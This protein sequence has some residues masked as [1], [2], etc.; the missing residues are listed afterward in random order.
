MPRAG[1]IV[2]PAAF[3]VL[4]GVAPAGAKNFTWSFNADILTLDPHSS[5]NTFTNA[6]ANNL[7]EG[8]TR[9]NEKIEIEPA[10]AERWELVNPT[11]WRFHLRRDVRFHDGAAFD[12][13]DVLFTWAR[14]N[15]PGA[16]ARRVIGDVKE[17]RRVDS[18]TVEIE[19]AQPNP[20]LLTA[21]THFFVMDREWSERN[22]SAAATNL[23][24][25][26]E[27]GAARQAN[28]TGPFRLV[29]R[30]P[31]ER[32]VLAVN[33]TWWDRP[34]HNLTEV[35]FQPIR[36]AATR[37]AALISGAIDATVEIPIQDIPRIE[38]SPALK[39][40]QGPELRTIYFGFDH[41]RDELLYSDVKG[42]NPLKDI[43]VRRAIFQAIDI[44]TI[45]R[46][47]MRG[48]AWPAGMLSSPF[49]TG[50]PAD[51][52]T[53]IAPFD[54]EASKRLLAEAGYP[55]GFSL[56]LS[57]P[58]DR[59][60][61][62]ERICLAV[63]SMLARVNIRV[64]AQIEPLN[65]WSRRLNGHDLSMFMIGH[66]GLPQADALATLADVVHT[67]TASEGGLNAGRYS[68]PAIDELIR[69]A[70]RETD[71]PKRFALMREAFRLERQDIAHVPLHQQPI[72]WASKRG[73]E[74]RQGPDNRLRLWHVRVE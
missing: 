13:D 47:V 54:P 23:Q 5:N 59:Y 4:I 70:A 30:A 17:M 2:L 14:L 24:E 6:F 31:D 37:T 26:Q 52:N 19:T 11:T 15:T 62:D 56:G 64:Q 66:A 7:Y 3:A 67:R 21:L 65:V 73:I 20:L 53:R 27:T 28:G 68:N 58:N 42:K 40:V 49:L 8:L 10:L 1:M 69:Q 61:Y 39:V 41:F 57:C 48:N 16:I 72:V 35:T 50:A 25:R 34:Q 44:E 32:T 33:P 46:S 18:H 45:R 38:Q 55:E 29:S 43:R 36:S 51:L 22:N 12:A 71:Q 60:V 63:I 9:H 74:M